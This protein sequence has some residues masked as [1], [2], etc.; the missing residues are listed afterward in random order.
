MISGLRQVSE[1]LH[2]HWRML[3]WSEVYFLASC[4]APAAK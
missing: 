2:R 4:R 3:E 1:V